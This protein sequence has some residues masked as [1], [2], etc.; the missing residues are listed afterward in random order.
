[1]KKGERRRE[2]MTGT[3]GARIG[4]ALTLVMA[5]T[6]TRAQAQD[7]AATADSSDTY[8]TLDGYGL[9]RIVE[10]SITDVTIRARTAMVKLKIVQEPGRS[11]RTRSLGPGWSEFRGKKGNLDVSIRLKSQGSG[12]TR[13]EVTAQ[14]GPAAYDKGMAQ[15]ILDE[16]GKS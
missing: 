1:V 7:S 10:G 4:L 11:R 13:V 6:V 2:T 14:T 3:T 5:A 9:G 12:R 16:I 15:Q 8:M